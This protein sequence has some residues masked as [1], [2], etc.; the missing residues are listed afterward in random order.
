MARFVIYSEGNSKDFEVQRVREVY[1]KIQDPILLITKQPP[2]I[3]DKNF[4]E[5][6][7]IIEDFDIKEYDKKYRT[8]KCITIPIYIECSASAE[9][10]WIIN[11]PSD[12]NKSE[13]ENMKM[14]LL[15]ELEKKCA[16]LIVS[17]RHHFT[18]RAWDYYGAGGEGLTASRN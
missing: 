2:R 12:E 7:E 11:V 9:I 16:D 18:I 3:I 13:E 4:I 14:A 8:K 5:K 1:D 17:G 6:T 15:A 10:N